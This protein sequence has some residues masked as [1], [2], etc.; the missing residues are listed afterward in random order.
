LSFEWTSNQQVGTE[1]LLVKFVNSFSVSWVIIVAEGE[2]KGVV[3]KCKITA[4]MSN[5][6]SDSDSDS[7]YAPEKD[8][9][10]EGEEEVVETVSTIPVSRKRKAD[11]LFAEMVQHENQEVESKMLK[12]V[13]HQTKKSKKS[14]S[15]D[16]KKEKLQDVSTKPQY[17][18]IHICSVLC[19]EIWL[20]SYVY[21]D[22]FRSCQPYLAPAVQR[23]KHL[24]LHRKV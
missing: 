3:V 20:L 4:T 5:L 14:K 15:K 10:D 12:T 1:L 16:K 18:R 8:A 22:F 11:S 9:N 21:F 17:N 6:E 23:L 7:D 19:P 13:S 24:L 2:A